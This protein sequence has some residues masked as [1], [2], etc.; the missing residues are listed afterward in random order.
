MK[1]N[2]LRLGSPARGPIGRG[3]MRDPTACSAHNNKIHY[4]SYYVI[5]EDEIIFSW[6]LK[7]A[8]EM[9]T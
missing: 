2:Q 5:I 3:L 8:E 7:V 1:W 4:E 6:W 9:N